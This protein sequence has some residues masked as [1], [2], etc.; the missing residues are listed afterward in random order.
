MQFPKF[1]SNNGFTIVE[2]LVV[3]AIVFLLSVFAFI[4]IESAKKSLEVQNV[5]AEFKI[6]LERAR[7]DSVKRGA[8]EAGEMA[9]VTI[10]DPQSFSVRTDLN[11]DG[12]LATN[13][14]RD[15]DFSYQNDIRF[16]GDDTVFPIVISFNRRGQ[17]TATD[18]I[19]NIIRPAFL[20][21]Q[22]NC[23][24]IATNAM[25]FQIVSVSAT[26]TVAVLNGDEM[27]ET[28]SAPENISTTT[29]GG[30]KPLVS[31]IPNDGSILDVI[32]GK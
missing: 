7:F 12:V 22:K 16:F 30:I 5:S 28:V 2:L 24:E 13:E 9:S 21:C 6:Y 29:T 15:I 23:E 27:L 11:Q 20:I 32:L 18:G 19:G 14:M 4:R 1:K 26:G 8:A 17:T 3:V 31:T 25:S 10:N